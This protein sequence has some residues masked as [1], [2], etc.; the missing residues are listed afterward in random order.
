MGK[1]I[2]RQA[3]NGPKF[4]LV[5]DNGTIIASS[6]VYRNI[7]TCMAGISSVKSIAVKA[8]LEDQTMET[9]KTQVHPKYEV[10][11]DEAGAYRFRLKAKNGQIVAFSKAFEQKEDCLACIDSVRA[12]I[13]GALTEDHTSEGLI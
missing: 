13:H 5:A 8:A 1:F 2:I 12:N 6:Q 10:Y 3:K 4:D 11:L 7:N 9:F